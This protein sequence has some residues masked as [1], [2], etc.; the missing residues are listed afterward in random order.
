M[1]PPF[2]QRFKI[3]WRTI[4]TTVGV[5]VI[6]LLYHW[7]NREPAALAALA[8]VF[9]MQADVPTSIQFG[10][11]RILGNALGAIIAGG[12]AQIEFMLGIDNPYVHILSITFGI[13]VLILLC[14]AFD[15]SKSIVNSSATFFVVLLT[16]STNEIFIYT[17]NRVLDAI[18]GVVIAVIINRLLPNPSRKNH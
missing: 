14:N 16:V 7:L 12:V 2:F 5:F 4:K 6:L 1:N 13:L 17:I 10:R 9:A 15:L 3:G 18:I 11:Y 8:C